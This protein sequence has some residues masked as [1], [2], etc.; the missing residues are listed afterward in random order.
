MP[1][2]QIPEK[3][4]YR[5]E[6][7]KSFT[8]GTQIPTTKTVKKW[9][10]EVPSVASLVD[11]GFYY[12]PTRKNPDQV[13]CFWCGRKENCIVGVRALGSHHLQSSPKCAYGLI[14]S[15][16]EYYVS[17]RDKER[18]WTEL[19]EEGRAPMSVTDPHSKSSI[20]LR[21]STFK[22]LWTLDSH[23]KCTATS[24]DLAKAGLYYSPLDKD[25]DRVICM[26]CDCPLDHWDP[27]D[28]PL[29][30]HRAN[31][32]SYCY[33]LLTLPKRLDISENMNKLLNL[34]TE[35]SMALPDDSLSDVDDSGLS[36]ENETVQKS[37]ANVARNKT[38][39]R[40]ESV[41]SSRNS[42]LNESTAHWPTLSPSP[43]LESHKESEFDAYDFSI[44][45]IE[46]TDH[47]SIF[48]NGST[49]IFSRKIKTRKLVPPPP[50]T[51]QRR[52]MA[53]ATGKDPLLLQVNDSRESEGSAKLS[54]R[55]KDQRLPAPESPVAPPSNP[56]SKREEVEDRL[57]DTNDSFDDIQNGS[58]FNSSDVEEGDPSYVSGVSN[59]ELSTSDDVSE[60]EKKRKLKS[61]DENE[62]KKQKQNT[63]E[64]SMDSDRFRQ[65]ITSPG[66]RKK[67]KLHPGEAVTSKKDDILDI[68]GHNIGDFNES[69]ISYFGKIHTP[70]KAD[71]GIPNDKDSTKTKPLLSFESSTKVKKSAFDDDD[72][73][74]FITRPKKSHIETAGSKQ[75][76]D[77]NSAQSLNVNAN[78]LTDA[79]ASM[80]IVELKVFKKTETDLD[81]SAAENAEHGVKSMKSL[82]K[83]KDTQIKD[84]QS[85][86]KDSIIL[87]GK[88]DVGHFL[89]DDRS[90]TRKVEEEIAV[91]NTSPQIAVHTDKK[92]SSSGVQEASNKTS[93]NNE[94][95]ALSKSN[96]VDAALSLTTKGSDNEIA[97]G[98]QKHDIAAEATT[99]ESTS[100]FIDTKAEFEEVGDSTN[101][102]KKEDAK[103]SED[104]VDHN[105]SG[106]ERD[107]SLSPSS[108]GEYVK[109]LRSLADEFVDASAIQ[110]PP[111]ANLLI[112]QS[113]NKNILE[114]LNELLGPSKEE[115]G[116]EVLLFDDPNE[117][118]QQSPQRHEITT[119]TTLESDKVMTKDGVTDHEQKSKVPAL[120][121][122]K[123]PTVHLDET[124]VDDDQKDNES[125]KRETPTDHRE[126][127]DTVDQDSYV[128]LEEQNERRSSVAVENAVVKLSPVSLPQSNGH[129]S[130]IRSSPGRFD[131]PGNRTFVEDSASDACRANDK[132]I[133]QEEGEG[134]EHN[135][136]ED[137]GP[138]SEAERTLGELKFEQR[139]LSV[140]H[141]ISASFIGASTPQ[142]ETKVLELEAIYKFHPR[143][144]IRNLGNIKEELKTLQ[145]T[146]EYLAEVSASNYELHNDTEGMLTDFIAAMPE[147]EESMTIKEWMQHNATTCARTVRAIASKMIEAYETEFDRLIEFVEELPTK[148]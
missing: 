9:G 129:S 53:M 65:I 45:D 84:N 102:T 92:E 90:S 94:A 14:Q 138:T 71:P 44:E 140:E 32:Y 37:S 57:R 134:S 97:E 31:S 68:S 34:P 146:M 122:T 59:G 98:T 110:E 10:H 75:K 17:A 69:D 60:K 30:E 66:K 132:D 67:V 116:E 120:T 105:E 61:H 2:K 101:G 72:F 7:E 121:T 5:D 54:A 22:N 77:E 83:N 108:Y 49:K 127:T 15:N 13:T 145:D 111:R 95:L 46:D 87:R 89:A 52:K 81:V 23:K 76:I 4:Q 78:K 80:D 63:S 93:S 25:N 91:T 40:E 43:E 3:Y 19:A 48:E 50:A 12:T 88:E 103:V 104:E 137:S 133:L 62:G 18:F 27:E 141:G 79:S 1:P 42:P 73:D 11:N 106:N 113:S 147:E 96:L 107:I 148:D 130:G 123:V 124:H 24:R 55:H 139:P 58:S 21:V 82:Q 144:D 29:S 36:V 70:S 33:F 125:V 115:E 8:S 131:S 56:E 74:F 119:D 136:R 39:E 47:G 118:Y 143:I 99:G 20:E 128:L 86:E 28:D 51:L 112:E 35:T 41:G 100:E 126:L 38:H 64:T 114:S 16:M 6:R 117:K 109:D 142:K 26:Y 85:L 135:E